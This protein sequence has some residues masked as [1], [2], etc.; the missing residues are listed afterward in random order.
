[1]GIKKCDCPFKVKAQLMTRGEGWKLRVVYAYHN[2]EWFET[3]HGHP[4]MGRLSHEKHSMLVDITKS[5][6]K[7][8]NIMLTLKDHN[9][10]NVINITRIYN[11]CQAFRRSLK[12]PRTK[13]QQLLKCFDENHYVY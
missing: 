7:P 9:V 3:F 10:D 1:M 5:M 8:K 13:M 12:G 2:L 6:V 4:Y 11:A